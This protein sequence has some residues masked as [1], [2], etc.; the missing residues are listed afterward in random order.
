MTSGPPCLIVVAEPRSVS[1]EGDT[2]AELSNS[3]ASWVDDEISELRSESGAWLTTTDDGSLWIDPGIDT[4]CIDTGCAVT[5]AGAKGPE[6]GGASIWAI[7]PDCNGTG[8]CG[9]GCM[10]DML[11]A[12]MGRRP[13]VAST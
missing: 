11:R 13:A 2:G 10:L 5:L 1:V 7:D 8:P 3:F 4:G 9:R 6:L 12:R